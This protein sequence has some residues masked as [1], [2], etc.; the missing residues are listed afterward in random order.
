MYLVLYYCHI[1]FSRT[2]CTVVAMTT[3]PFQCPPG[4]T[5]S[6]TQSSEQL[7]HTLERGTI[8]HCY[9]RCYLLKH[10]DIQIQQ[11]IH[12]LRLEMPWNSIRFTN[13]HLV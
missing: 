3:G 10:A 9:S 2:T 12:H 13:M 11:R 5:Q 7:H 6:M 1:L 4:K 8:W